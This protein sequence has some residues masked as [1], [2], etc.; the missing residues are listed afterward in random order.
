MSATPH[1]REAG[2]ESPPERPANGRRSRSGFRALVLRLHFYAGLLIAPFLVIAAL[3]G[4]LYAAA[5]PA[6]RIIYSDH[7]RVPVGEQ[8]LSV[9]EQVA[10]AREEYPEGTISGVR[11][12]A[13]PG[14]TTR[15]L[16]TLPDL[17]PSHRLGVFVDPYTADVIGALEVYGS[18]GALPARWWI[19]E[20]HRGLHLGDFGRLYS[21]LAAS[22]LIV[23]A[24]G[25]VVLWI[26][27]RR[28]ANRLRRTLLP[29]RG[30]RGRRATLTWHGVVG[31][32]ISVGLMALAATGLT[33]SQYAG[34]NVTDLRA[35]L[36]WQTPTVA[37]TPDGGSAPGDHGDHGDHADHGDHGDH[38][39]H[40]AGAEGD[41]PDI[42]PELARQAAEG[43]G[44]RAPVEIVYPAEP[45]AAYVVKEIK[46]NWPIRHDAVAVDSA[47]AVVT[48]TVRYDDWPLAAKLAR[49]GVD[50]HMGLLFGLPNQLALIALCGAL[51]AVVVLG[52]RMW[53]QR[54]PTREP[55][56]WGRPPARGAWRRVPLAVLLPGAA[57]TLLIG[58]FVPLLGIS[59]LVFLAVDALLGLRARR[60]R[61]AAASATAE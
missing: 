52:Y 3:T 25:G 32:W 50:G 31:L 47:S 30:L 28:E 1:L 5:V 13:E 49:V 16:L 17:G 41:A 60:R 12:G 43:Q 38:A 15:V 44:L 24:A 51:I 10:A 37:T 56:G 57:V 14:D 35:S 9:D 40:E 29:E 21:E 55:R 53:W 4:M 23:V 18:S 34:S 33:W 2:E 54:R 6:E 46:P 39:G 48:D 11:P 36:S 26:G 22:W 61:E 8:V 42:G 58:W 19:D 27:R 7:L 45:G 59:L 20:M